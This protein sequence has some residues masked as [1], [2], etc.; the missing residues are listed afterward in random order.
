ML[1]GITSPSGITAYAWNPVKFPQLS[2]RDLFWMVLVC[3]MYANCSILKAVIA[4]TLRTI[5]GSLLWWV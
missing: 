3:A 2:L 4:A 1:R 5:S